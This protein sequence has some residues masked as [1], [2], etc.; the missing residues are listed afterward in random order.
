MAISNHEYI[1]YGTAVRAKELSQFLEH[2][3]Q[4]NR[5]AEAADKRKTPV[6]IWGAHG[7]GKTQIVESFARDRDYA[8]QYVA[9]API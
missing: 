3:G 8:F 5:R 2:M 7:I 9:P 6:C 1:Q 4:A